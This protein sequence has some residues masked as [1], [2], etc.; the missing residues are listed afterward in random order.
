[1][2]YLI[3]TENPNTHL[4]SGPRPQW[5]TFEHLKRAGSC[6]LLAISLD[7]EESTLRLSRR[8]IVQ[9]PEREHEG[10]PGKRGCLIVNERVCL[11]MLVAL[12]L[13]RE[14]KCKHVEPMRETDRYQVLVP[15]KQPR[16][17]MS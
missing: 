4:I 3:F 13:H 11:R 7:C 1:M 5:R 12:C 2:Q 16:K 14:T 17:D 6:I 15:L 8:L 9:G 10:L